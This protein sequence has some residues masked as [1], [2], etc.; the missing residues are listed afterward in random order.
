MAETR[1]NKS[2]AGNR[3]SS[4]SLGTAVPIRETESEQFHER[5]KE[6]IAD[7]KLAWFAKECGFSDSLLGSYLRGEKR[8]G[9]INLI[10]IS[11]VG[12]VTVDWLATGRLPKTRAELRAAQAQAQYHAGGDAAPLPRIDGAL[13]RQCLA[14]C[15]TVYGAPFAAAPV[16]RQ[17]EHAADFYNALLPNIGPRLSLQDIAARDAGSLADTLRGFVALGAVLP[18]P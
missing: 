17:L 3:N 9:L 13:L 10:A 18:F 1:M 16:A 8:P 5:L 4:D 6:A 11:R 15:T 2:L 14:A 7:R 12:G